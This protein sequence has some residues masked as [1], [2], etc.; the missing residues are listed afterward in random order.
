MND[1][2][3]IRELIS[4]LA[5]RMRARDVSA[6]MD[7]MTD[8]IVFMPTSTNDHVVPAYVGFDDVRGM[9]EQLMSTLEIEIRQAIA[10]IEVCG[11]VA[12]V[13]DTYTETTRVD[14]GPTL[15]ICG[16]EMM[17]LRRVDGSWRFARYIFSTVPVT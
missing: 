8:D 12:W 1:D 6:I 11:D 4:T 14:G 16:A 9:F 13:R 17:V 3:E 10:E 5:R 2:A 7:L 15:H